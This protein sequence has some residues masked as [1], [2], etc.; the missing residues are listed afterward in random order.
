MTNLTRDQ[1]DAILEFY[2]RCGDEA[3][4]NRGRDLVASIPAAAEL[5]AR[6]EETL[7]QLDSIKY[8]PCPDNLAELTIARLKL[9][10][11]SGQRQLR[12]L[13]AEEQK[14]G[15]VSDKQIDTTKRSFWRIAEI[16]AAAA[17]IV[18]GLG[19]AF[20]PLSNARQIERQNLCKMNLA[21]I[22]RGIQSYAKD[23]N[24]ALPA[25]AM[26]AG[27]PWWRIG[28]RSEKNNSNTR[29]PWLLVKDGYAKTDAFVCPGS[30]DGKILNLSPAELR[31]L[32]DFPS[33]QN[34]NYSYILMCD[35]TA[36]RQ[37]SG[38]LTV[39]MADSNP[40]FE[41]IFRKN[42]KRDGDR[43]PM[44]FINDKMRRMRSSNHRGKGQ[45]ILFSIGSAE[46]KD[47]RTILDDDIYMIRDTDIYSGCEVPC[48][49][50]DIFLVP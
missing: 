25:V 11:S 37:R 31:K 24:G 7:T 14:K 1:K 26:P 17:M 19:L 2:F 32:N 27:S 48:D 44:I 38:A 39:L 20:I 45:N 47:K 40:V 46:F 49:D 4:L 12:E 36:Q 8:E 43:F 21:R 42:I 23:N 3:N 9:A 18:V 30:K 22:G 33:W 41:K 34:I 35:K 5:Y 50:S 29:G 28:D 16:A 15:S 10:A 6:L 13:L